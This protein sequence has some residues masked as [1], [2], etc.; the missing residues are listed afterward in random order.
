[1]HPELS[2]RFVCLPLHSVGP[3]ACPGRLF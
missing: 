2:M 3:A 1:M